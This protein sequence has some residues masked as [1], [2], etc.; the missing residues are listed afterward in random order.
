MDSARRE[1]KPVPLPYDTSANTSLSQ[2]QRA[3]DG[4]CGTGELSTRCGP[5]RRYFF[6]IRDGEKVV[7][8]SSGTELPDIAAACR[9]ALADPR[10]VLPEELATGWTVSGPRIEIADD[11]G[12]ILATLPLRRPAN[13]AGKPTAPLATMA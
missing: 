12:R 8:D 7:L 11:D 9:R 10:S 6:H 1:S 13:L 5:M 2:P 3:A 4:E